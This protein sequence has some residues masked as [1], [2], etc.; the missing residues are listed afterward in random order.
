[1]NEV[2][3]IITI[4]LLMKHTNSTTYY[5]WGNGQKINQQGDYTSIDKINQ[6]KK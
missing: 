5:L 1:M 6:R 3:E 2:I 4:H